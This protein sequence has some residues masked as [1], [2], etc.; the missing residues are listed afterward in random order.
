MV[1]V[2]GLFGVSSREDLLVSS[3]CRMALLE[4]DTHTGSGGTYGSPRVRDPG[5]TRRTMGATMGLA[6][7]FDV[8]RLLGS[9]GRT[10]G[11]REVNHGLW[12]PAIST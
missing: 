12:S 3:T 1:A 10:P 2:Y 5:P 4:V 9:P 7:A 8:H 6:A 11:D